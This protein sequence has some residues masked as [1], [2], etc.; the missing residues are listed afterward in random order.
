MEQRGAGEEV[1]DGEGDDFVLCAGGAGAGH[2]AV[3]DDCAGFCGICPGEGR[4][5]RGGREG[6]VFE[7]EAARGVAVG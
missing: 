7:G 4:G 5:R 1:D 2:F 3:E 6:V